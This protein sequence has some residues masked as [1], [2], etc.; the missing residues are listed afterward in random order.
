MREGE[1][2]GERETAERQRN[3]CTCDNVLMILTLTLEY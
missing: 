2:R 1:D 3:I